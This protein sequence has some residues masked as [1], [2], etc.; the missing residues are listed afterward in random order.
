MKFV[1]FVE[2]ATERQSLPEFFKRW[3]DPRLPER[4][5]FRVVRFEGWRDYCDEIAK[6][7]ALNLSGKAGSDVIAGVGLL[8][9]YGPTFYP[10]RLKT[11]AERYHWA[12]EH[13]EQQVAHPRFRQ[14][15]AVHETEA[16]VLA[17]P[18]ILPSEIRRGLPG[19]STQPEAVNLDEPPAKLLARLY[20]QKLGKSY[21]KVID[22]AD[23]FQ[24]L[25]PERAA[26]RCPHLRLML[27][28]M[29]ALAQSRG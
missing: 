13:L 9:L 20:R 28:E 3:L 11:A 23:L 6:K 29:L 5:G 27:E 2:G 25:A 26:E 4:V 21:R 15:F 16:W 8:D 18:E 14:H 22:G 17:Q 19:G 12:K 1:L 7:V 24:S 10:G